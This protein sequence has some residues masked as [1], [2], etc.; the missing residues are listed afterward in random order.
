[1]GTSGTAGA[2]GTKP[3]A[4]GTC[5]T[6]AGAGS[7]VVIGAIGTGWGTALGDGGTGVDSG[8]SR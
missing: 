7:V 4:S 3:A 1:M 2:G 5:S 8:S 6:G